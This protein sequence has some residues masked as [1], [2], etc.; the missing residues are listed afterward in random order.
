MKI[1]CTRCEEI[2]KP[3][4]AVWKELSNDERNNKEVL[5]AKNNMKNEIA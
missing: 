2:L 1:R 3:E 4:R 5:T